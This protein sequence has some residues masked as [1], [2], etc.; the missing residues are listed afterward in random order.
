M[1]LEGTIGDA[2][3]NKDLDGLLSPSGPIAI[4]HLDN[5]PHPVFWLGLRNVKIS[6]PAL[7]SVP[8]IQPSPEVT[9]FAQDLLRACLLYDEKKLNHLYAPDV[10]LLPGNRL[11]YFGLEVPGKMTE[12]GVSIKREEMLVALKKQAA[13]DPIPFFMA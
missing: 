12:S 5:K 10:Q 8:T 4:Y 7:Q 1:K 11:F 3:E 6:G 9:A 2:S 13:V